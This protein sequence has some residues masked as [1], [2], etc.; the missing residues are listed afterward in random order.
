MLSVQYS[1]AETP[2][3]GFFKTSER[4]SVKG[5]S[6]TYSHDNGQSERSIAKDLS[7]IFLRLV[8][9]DSDFAGYRV[10]GLGSMNL[11][12]KPKVGE[13]GSPMIE[14]VFFDLEKNS[15]QKDRTRITVCGSRK[16]PYEIVLKSN[17][18]ITNEIV[19][20]FA[21][22]E[23]IKIGDLHIWPKEGIAK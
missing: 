7:A 8:E 23:T 20:R 15:P 11:V 5:P 21:K 2:C 19:E 6:H 16:D 14:V 13:D 12:A 17:R 10:S 22:N 4:V 18:R 3:G 9:A 1:H